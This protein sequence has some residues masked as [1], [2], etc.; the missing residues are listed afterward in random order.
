M[1]HETR[2][3]DETTMVL[4][5]LRCIPTHPLNAMFVEEEKEKKTNRVQERVDEIRVRV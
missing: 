2:D 1:E 4:K 3:V 5:H